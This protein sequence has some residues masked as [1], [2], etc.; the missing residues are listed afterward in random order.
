MFNQVV[1]N[2]RQATEGTVQ[3]QQ[4]IFKK[5]LNL[6]PGTSSGAPS[7]PDQARDFQKKWVETVGDL[8]KKQREVTETH[9]KA[10]IENIEKAFQVAEAKTP[11]EIRA[12]SIELWQQCFDNLRKVYEAQLRGVEVVMEKWSGFITNKPKS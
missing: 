12:K 7:W 5:W 6:W 8:L 10:G 1:D 9:F 3:L 2:F 11:G 4:E